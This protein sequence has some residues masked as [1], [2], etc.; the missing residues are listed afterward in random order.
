VRGDPPRPAAARPLAAA[1]FLRRIEE[2]P[3]AAVSHLRR[4]VRTESVVHL[5]DLLL[6]RTDWG[7]DP[8]VA[9]AIAR[10][11]GALLAA[12]SGPPGAAAEPVA[13]NLVHAA[14]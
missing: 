13:E 5:D 11:I 4:L 6:R 7:R 3:Y 12:P 9:A 2:D 14:G 8:A 10:R 1:D